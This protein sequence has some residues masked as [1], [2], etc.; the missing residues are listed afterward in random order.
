MG[1]AG[2]CSSA[3]ASVPVGLNMF[4]K[5][6]LVTDSLPPPPLASR[7]RRRGAT[8]SPVPACV[9]TRGVDDMPAAAAGTPVAAGAAA[10]ADAPVATAVPGRGRAGDL[11]RPLVGA[12][13]PAVAPVRAAAPAAGAAA[14]GGARA[15]AAAAVGVAEVAS[16]RP[17]D[18]AAGAGAAAGAE[19]EKSVSW[20]GKC[21]SYRSQSSEK[22]T[23]S[24]MS[25]PS[26]S[27][28]SMSPTHV[29]R[30]NASC[31]DRS[32]NRDMTW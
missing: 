18:S 1:L 15:T 24:S 31:P 28:C 5:R 27:A 10:A 26:S 32:P 13:A 3:L 17:R 19:R 25:S 12:L 6:E 9:G 8:L 23:V 30:W 16:A 29:L 22:R 20:T 7:A 11:P 21:A 2:W 4:S 14:T